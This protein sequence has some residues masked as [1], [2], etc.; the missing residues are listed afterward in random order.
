MRQPTDVSLVQNYSLARRLHE[1]GMMPTVISKYVPGTATLVRTFT[2]TNPALSFSRGYSK[3]WVRSHNGF[4]LSNILFKIYGV[5]SGDPTL[6]KGIDIVYLAAAW[7]VAIFQY[8]ELLRD[9]ICDISRFAYLLQKVASNEYLVFQC[10]SSNC[11]NKFIIHESCDRTHCWACSENKLLNTKETTTPQENSIPNT[12]L[13]ENS[14]EVHKSSETYTESFIVSNL[15]LTL[16]KSK[17]KCVLSESAKDHLR[18]VSN[19]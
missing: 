16:H 10:G 1:L 3:S 11:N 6:K 14:Y 17:Q 4:K 2:D 18:L 5:V 13:C 7:E 9:K 15:F 12:T 8:P 19:Y